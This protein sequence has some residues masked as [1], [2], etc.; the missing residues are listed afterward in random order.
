MNA[1]RKYRLSFEI[2][3]VMNQ[4]VEIKRNQKS[5]KIG[6]MDQATETYLAQL[7]FQREVFPP[8]H[9]SMVTIPIFHLMDG[10]I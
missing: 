10:I 2:L 1:G 5:C 9:H 6:H 4:Q 8:R 3:V 7:I